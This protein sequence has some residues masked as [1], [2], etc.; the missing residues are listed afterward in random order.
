MPPDRKP[1]IVLVRHGETEWSRSGRHTGRTDVPLTDA[2]RTQARR[3]ASRI[4]GRSFTRVLT[5]PL[6]RA[7]DTCRLAGL[8]AAAEGRPE[9]RE[10]DYGEYEGRT[11]AE[12]REERP[13]WS[14]WRDGCPG[15]EAAEDVGARLDP[16]V[17]ELAKA[18][19]DMAVF[20]HGHSLRV[21]AARWIELPA[22]AGARLPLGTAAV[23][24]LGRERE[25]RAILLWNDTAGE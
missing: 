21:L 11:T 2:G 3:L 23:S 12:I 13:G 10:W 25:T 5:S 1:E 15:G 24:V 17:E 4:A 18:S 20:G 8:G 19:G 16:L 6:T 22:V 7:A 9:L 14:T